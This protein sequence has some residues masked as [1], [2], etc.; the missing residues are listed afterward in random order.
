MENVNEEEVEMRYRKSE[1]KSWESY[2]GLSKGESERAREANH[3]SPSWLS[4]IWLGQPF[5]WLADQSIEGRERD[6]VDSLYLSLTDWNWVRLAIWLAGR[7]INA[8]EGERVRGTLL[9]S[10]W[11]CEV[12]L[13]QPFDWLA[14][15]LNRERESER[16]SPLPPC[17]LQLE[18]GQPIKWLADQSKREREGEGDSPHLPFTKLAWARPAMWLAGRSIEQRE[19]L[20]SPPLAQVSLSLASHLFGWP[21]N[22]TER[23]RE[24]DRDSPLLRLIKLVWARPANQMAGRSIEE[25]EGGRGDSPLLP[26]TK[27]SCAPPAI[28]LAGQSI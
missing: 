12:E 9:S 5:Y 28:R 14:D 7:S 15:G 8:R 25:R 23:G 11:P 4:K 2:T 3:L 27:W 20:P 10:T 24:S 22:Q 18:L 16:D 17:P 1:E 6:K 21:I 26:L 19:G 13:G